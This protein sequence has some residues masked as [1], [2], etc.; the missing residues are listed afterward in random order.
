MFSSLY[1]YGK[2]PG[3]PTCG[4]IF[5]NSFIRAMPDG[6]VFYANLRDVGGRCQ[7]GWPTSIRQNAVNSASWYDRKPYARVKIT[8]K[9]RKEPEDMKASLEQLNAAE[10]AYSFGR[11][12]AI[13]NPTWVEAR[14]VEKRARSLLMDLGLERL[15]MSLV[16]RFSAAIRNG[17]DDVVKSEDILRNL[18]RSQAQAV[19]K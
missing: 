13:L 15:P 18:R 19:R 16:D 5:D 11:H 4:A 7:S 6:T 17:F 10:I 3:P 14:D 12:L 8:I 9:K 2:N 1:S